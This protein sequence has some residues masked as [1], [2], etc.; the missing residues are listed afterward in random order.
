MP[1]VIGI[2]PG[3]VSVDIC[4]LDDGRVFIDRSLPT[5]EAL[6]HP[7]VLVGLLEGAAPLDLVAGPSGY[8]LQ[9]TAA[10]DLTDT[11]FRLAYLAAEGESGGIAGLRSLMRTL[12]RSSTPVVLTP[13]VVHLASVP[14]HRKVN[15]VDMGTADKLCA[16][17]LAIHE[18]AERRGCRERDV[19]F[20]LLEL[21]GAFTAAIAVQDGRV[22]DGAGGTSGP[23]GARAAGALDGEVAFLAGSVSKRLL[24]GGGAATIAGVPDAPAESLAAPSTLRGRLAWEAYLE[25][26]VKAVAALA[27]SVPGVCEVILSGRLA[28]AAGVREELA[29]RLARVHVA[30]GFSPASGGLADS[31]VHV[32]TGFAEAAQQA[33]QGAALI[34]DGLAGGRSAALVETLGIREARGTVLD[35]LYVIDPVAARARLGIAGDGNA[36]DGSA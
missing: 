12:A 33:A 3:T 22:V 6:A 25:S 11:D 34:A 9:L 7:S 4:G 8:G 15:R 5:S 13:G 14:A 21:G 19:S 29:E 26:A 27:V 32:L 28:R 18:R 1:R 31:S 23:L 35:H 10:R 24:F 2:D 36:G 30:R 20:V 17:A 16:A